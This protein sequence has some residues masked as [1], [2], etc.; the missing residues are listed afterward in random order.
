MRN[1]QKQMEVE[2]EAFNSDKFR[3][4]S[5]A[6]GMISE[7]DQFTEHYENKIQQYSTE[8]Q[9]LKAQRNL[10]AKILTD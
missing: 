5:V 10:L 4:K 6:K 7:I 9:K 3:D 1:Q 8:I 2:A